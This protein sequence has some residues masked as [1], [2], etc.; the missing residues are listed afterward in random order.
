[1]SAAVQVSYI[2]DQ[3]ISNSPGLWAHQIKAYASRLRSMLS[4]AQR[5]NSPQQ[6]ILSWCSAPDAAYNNPSSCVTHGCDQRILNA[7]LSTLAVS[8][9]VAYIPAAA[10]L[11]CTASA[12]LERP[13][14]VLSI[15]VYP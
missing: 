14:A 12:A 6:L 7:S 8:T 5:S 10:F 2:P 1:M 3:Q 13:H 9:L 11:G 15:G 4:Q